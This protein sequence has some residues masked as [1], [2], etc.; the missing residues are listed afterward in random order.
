MDIFRNIFKSIQTD[1]KHKFYWR[2]LATTLA[3]VVVFV[4]TY[5]L[6][7]PAITMEAEVAEELPG[8]SMEEDGFESDEIVLD[9]GADEEVDGIASEDS[10]LDVTDENES[11]GEEWDSDA[12]IIDEENGDGSANESSAS[13]LSEEFSSYTIRELTQEIE[14]TKTKDKIKVHLSFDENAL[15]PDGTRLEVVDISEAENESE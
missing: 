8:F 4:T 11:S 1:K 6:I 15:I 2:A 5:S 3:G 10:G 9:S 14:N 12:L 13:A 7:L